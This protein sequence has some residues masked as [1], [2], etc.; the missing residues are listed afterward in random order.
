MIGEPRVFRELSSILVESIFWDA[1]YERMLW[2]DITAGTVHRARLDGAV[3]GSDDEVVRLPPPVSSIQPAAGG[4]YITALRDEV[5]TL[6][7]DLRAT[8]TL[9]RTP[10]RHAGIRNNEGKVDPFGRF[11]LGAMNVTTGAADA[12][13]FVIDP[14]GG[15]EVIRGGFGVANGFEWS[16]DGRTMYVTDTST[17][18]VYRGSY[19]P[20]AAPLGELE[21][22]LVGEASDGLA[23][24]RTGAFWNGVYTSGELVRWGDDDAVTARVDLPAVHVT[25]VAFG[26]PHLDTLFIGTARENATEAQLRDAPLSGS[27]FALDAPA[28]GRAVHTF[29]VVTAGA[30]APHPTASNPT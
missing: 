25:S 20:G 23:L 15:V 14:D 28:T 18:T 29:G 16:D 1:R 5:V 22:A 4:G 7:A 12:G 26:G 11:V 24:D 10:H 27:I 3:D 19:R 9:A 30:D 2:V 21:P 17:S 13:L 6:G 8:G